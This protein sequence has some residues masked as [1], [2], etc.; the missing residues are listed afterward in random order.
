M[1]LRAERVGS[2]PLLQP[3]Q[4][5]P[6]PSAR[7]SSSPPRQHLICL[8]L[9]HGTA[10]LSLLSL[11]LTLMSLSLP[12]SIVNLVSTEP[13]TIHCTLI[14]IDKKIKSITMYGTK[15]SRAKEKIRKTILQDSGVAQWAKLLLR[16]P[17]SHIG[18]IGSNCGWP[19]S[20]PNSADVPGKAR[21]DGPNTRALVTQ[22][23][24]GGSSCILALDC[25]RPDFAVIWEVNQ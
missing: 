25:P 3:A 4:G 16:M 6:A 8:C 10:N 20:D 22:G 5:I 11:C 23:R 12:Q 2:H 13:S 7:R 17:K 15:H 18:I 24:P 1:W 21:D 19:T 14:N 9:L